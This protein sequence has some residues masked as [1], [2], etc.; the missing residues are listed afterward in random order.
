VWLFTDKILILLKQDVEVSKMCRDFVLWMIPGLFPA[1]WFE[2]IRRHLQA[3][4]IVVPVTVIILLSI[5]IEACYLWLTISVFELGLIGCPIAVMLIYWTQFVLL[6]AWVLG[7]RELRST[8]PGFS[9]KAFRGWWRFLKLAIPG[10]LMSCMEGWGFDIMSLFAGWIGTI[11]LAAHS[12]LINTY[13]I[14]YMIPLGVSVAA[15]TRVGTLLGARKP[16]R[17]RLSYILT[18]FTCIFF[19]LLVAAV[20]IIGAKP[21]GMLFC[22]DKDVVSYYTQLMPIVCLV[23]LVDGA[24][25]AGSGALRGLGRQRLGMICNF[26]SFYI[27]GIP[28]GYVMAFI[29]KLGMFGI[30]IGLGMCDAVSAVFFTV[31]LLCTNWSKAAMDIAI[32]AEAV[33]LANTQREI[34]E[35]AAAAA[36]EEPD[37][38]TKL[39]PESKKRPATSGRYGT[40]GGGSHMVINEDTDG[41]HIT[42]GSEVMGEADDAPVQGPISPETVRRRVRDGDGDDDDDGD[43]TGGGGAGNG[44]ADGEAEQTDDT[45]TGTESKVTDT[46][47][48]DSGTAHDKA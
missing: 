44:G 20:L 17:A 29:L 9:K 7:R 23:M 41:R 39:S 45:H 42:F 40:G 18:L 35:A 22:P 12:A 8:W 47:S 38:E 46:E 19:E 25:I 36:E 26:V 27:I 3:M 2:A 13:Y 31:V 14:A 33:K 48:D 4:N 24:Q 10:A 28:L 21:I 11:Q 32:E 43:G 6:C 15:T 37:E 34:R 30:W 5:P 1:M 16:V